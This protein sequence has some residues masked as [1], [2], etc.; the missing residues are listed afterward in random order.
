MYLVIVYYIYIYIYSIIFFLLVIAFLLSTVPS[1]SIDLY[2]V[3]EVM[4]L[5][6]TIPH[7]ITTCSMASI[8]FIFIISQ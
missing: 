6:Y 1:Y 3:L 7:L 2:W 5:L 4:F 8:Q